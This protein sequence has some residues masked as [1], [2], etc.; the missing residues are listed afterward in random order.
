MQQVETYE[1]IAYQIEDMYVY[2]SSRPN[3]RSSRS[4]RARS[5]LES[6][7]HS[8]MC[9]STDVPSVKID[10][11]L[12]VHPKEESSKESKQKTKKKKNPMH[13]IDAQKLWDVFDSETQSN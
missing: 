5:S 12:P 8:S 6:D 2:T 11:K 7:T 4:S 10:T 9:Y 3:P 1:S 13:A